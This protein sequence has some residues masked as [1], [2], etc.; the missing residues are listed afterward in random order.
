MP[1]IEELPALS[2]PALADLLPIVDDSSGVTKRIAVSQLLAMF[3]PVGSIYTSVLDGNPS[4]T[5]GFGTWEA[6]GAGKVPVGKDAGDPDFATLEGTG[7]TKDVTLTEAQMPAHGHA[8][9]DPGH[10]HVEN[11]NNT[12]TGALRGWGAPDTS[13]NNSTATGYSTATAATG[14]TMGN[15]GGGQAHQNLQPYIVVRMWKRIA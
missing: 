4:V 14:I 15:T 1:R 3:W 8:V 9:N 12:S 10:A 11:S 6:F 7:G 13:T 5:L 2:A